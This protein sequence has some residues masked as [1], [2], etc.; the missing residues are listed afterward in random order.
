M[1]YSVGGVWMKELFDLIDNIE[2]NFMVIDI[3]DDF[4]YII[5]FIEN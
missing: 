5:Y 4:G 2:F 1:V 3:K